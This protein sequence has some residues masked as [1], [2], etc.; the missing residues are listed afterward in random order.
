MANQ[1]GVTT[2]RGRPLDEQP[3]IYPNAVDVASGPDPDLA[4]EV[5]ACFDDGGAL[6]LAEACDAADPAA[7]RPTSVITPN[8]GRGSEHPTFGDYEILDEVA[9][10][11][12]GIVYKARQISLKRI[13]AL[14]MILAGQLAGAGAV[15]RFLIEAEAAAS[16][17]HPNILPI[18]E[19]GERD[20]QHYFTMK[21]IEGGSLSSQLAR[22]RDDCPAAARLL[23]RVAG[24]VHHAHQRGILHRD[25]K[26]ANILLDSQ[27]EPH[28]TDFGL[29]KRVR[30]DGGASQ[31][32]QVV[33]TASYMA[34][35]Q[36][37]PRPLA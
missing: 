8:Q 5:A 36:A 6:P 31:S 10:G 4:A 21:L 29:A 32:V 30:D 24:A 35:E 19:V 2:G 7:L 25:L 28:V 9:R 37:W 13:V 12:M 3:T 23:A 20:G 15:R 27:G 22:F 34:P 16:L 11:G 1:N 14:K 18:Y 17:D 33:G 26:P